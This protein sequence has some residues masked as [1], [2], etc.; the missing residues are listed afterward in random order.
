MQALNG[1]EN[2]KELS[3]E[4]IST[5]KEIFMKEQEQVITEEQLIPV[6]KLKGELDGEFEAFYLAVDHQGQTYI[7]RSLDFSRDAYHKSKGWEEISRQE[8]ERF[9]KQLHFTP[10]RGKGLKP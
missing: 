10:A 9:E 6:G 4:S 8:L 5:P 1:Q 7:N 2:S 3:V